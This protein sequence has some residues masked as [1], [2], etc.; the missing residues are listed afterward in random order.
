MAYLNC[1]HVSGLAAPIGVASSFLRIL[2]APSKLHLIRDNM[3]DPRPPE[4][5]GSLLSY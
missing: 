2:L 5:G 3:A 4:R 1:H